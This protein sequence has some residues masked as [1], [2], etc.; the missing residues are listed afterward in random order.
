M[1]CQAVDQVLQSVDQRFLAE[2]SD[3]LDQRLQRQR[4]GHTFEGLAECARP[5]G[6]LI[7]ITCSI[8]EEENEE[9]VSELLSRRP[10][11]SLEPL[12]DRLR[13]GFGA[14]IAGPGKW[15]ALPTAEHDGFTVHALRKA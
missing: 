11:W 4:L 14:H 7:A 6:L 5:G 13:D 8:E 10:R 12:E 15:R 2:R 3:H 9:V 1:A